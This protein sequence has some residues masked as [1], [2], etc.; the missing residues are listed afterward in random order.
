MNNQMDLD[1]QYYEELRKKLRNIKIQEPSYEDHRWTQENLQKYKERIASEDNRQNRGCKMFF[2]AETGNVLQNDFLIASVVAYKKQGFLPKQTLD[3]ILSY[4]Q[5]IF[6]VEV[7]VEAK[8]GSCEFYKA[9]YD[10]LE[11]AR[12]CKDQKV[13]Q[14]FEKYICR[15]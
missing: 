8:P 1:E 12:D 7:M 14:E 15:M 5:P 13:R 6:R 11:V 3:K 2:L 10:L 4:E 9:T